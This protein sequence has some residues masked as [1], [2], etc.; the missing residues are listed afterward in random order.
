MLDNCLEPF[1]KFVCVVQH[2]NFNA[3]GKIASKCVTRLQSIILW[4][5]SFG[6][7][8]DNSGMKT[9]CKIGNGF[10]GDCL[11]FTTPV[12]FIVVSVPMPPTNMA[13]TATKENRQRVPMPDI[14]WPL[15]RG[16]K[17][18]EEEY[19]IFHNFSIRVQ[20]WGCLIL[21]CLKTISQSHW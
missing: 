7:R 1:V 10:V 20:C 19:N 15:Q 18:D 12:S 11:Q 5:I 21:L 17:R 9:A 2:P 16:R 8:K 13:G 3:S 14:P 6:S 4:K